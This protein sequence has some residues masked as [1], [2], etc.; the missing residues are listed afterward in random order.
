MQRPLTIL[1]L[2]LLVA[3]LLPSV[4][5]SAVNLKRC[6]NGKSFTAPCGE[7]AGHDRKNPGAQCASRVAD[8]TYW[9]QSN[10]MDYWGFCDCCRKTGGGSCLQITTNES[11]T[12][13]YYDG[14]PM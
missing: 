6:A 12:W 3:V 4:D 5:S 10:Q 9:C 14:A 1:I 13:K 2:S 8:V 7:K 11:W